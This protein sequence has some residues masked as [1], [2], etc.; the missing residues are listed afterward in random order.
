MLRYHQRSILIPFRIQHSQSQ[1][2]R[3]RKPQAS[4]EFSIALSAVCEFVK[5]PR[6][7]EI[8]TVTYIHVPG[9]VLIKD[10]YNFKDNV[11]RCL[12]VGCKKEYWQDLKKK[13]NYW[14]NY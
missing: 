11:F 13:K 2:T 7:G 3:D 5:W 10:L 14:R 12:R 1:S 9:I 6:C 8:T 4:E